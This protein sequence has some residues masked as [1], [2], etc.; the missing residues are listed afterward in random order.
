MPGARYFDPHA[1]RLFEQAQSN[2]RRI[3]SFRGQVTP[4]QA[5]SVAALALANPTWS[6]GVAYTLGMGGIAPDSAEARL[7]TQAQ[8]KIDSRKGLLGRLG[9]VV[10]AP[11]SAFRK[12]ADE[13]IYDPLKGFSRGMSAGPQVFK[14]LA[15]EGIRE[16]MNPA[17]DFS[18]AATSIGAGHRE[19]TANGGYLGLLTGSTDVDFGDG[20]FIGGRAKQRQVDGAREGITTRSGKAVTAGR[21]LAGMV[22]ESETSRG[23]N[24]LSGLVDAVLSLGL[25]PTTYVGGAVMQPVRRSRNLAGSSRTVDLNASGDIKE[26]MERSAAYAKAKAF[27]D[28]E[29][30]AAEYA[31]EV[32]EFG[33]VNPRVA[34]LKAAR[35]ARQLTRREFE[36]SLEAA[37]EQIK[38]G[39]GLLE[40]G[41]RNTYLPEK[42][43]DWLVKSDAGQ[44][45]RTYLRNET[46]FERMRQATKGKLPVA[47]VAK[48]TEAS[49]DDTVLRTLAD[50]I[51]LGGG[52]REKFKVGLLDQ[53]EATGP[54]SGLIDLG[55]RVR[56]RKRDARLWALLPG[57]EIDF[58]NMDDAVE[59]LNRFQQ[60][61]KLPLDE[62]SAN[63][64]ALVKADSPEARYKAVRSVLGQVASRVETEVFED[65]LKKLSRGKAAKQVLNTADEAAKADYLTDVQKRAAQRAK[66]AAAAVTKAFDDSLTASRYLADDVGTR[67]EL[68]QARPVRQ[69]ALNGEAVDVADA[70][71]PHL[72]LEG[73]GRNFPLPDA[74]AIRRVLTDPRMR[75]L[76]DPD[77]RVGSKT[78]AVEDAADFFRDK[79]WVPMKLLRGAYAVR[80]LIEAQLSSAAGGYAAGFYHPLHYL[81]YVLWNPQ[82]RSMLE[83]TT[84]GSGRL[85]K[86]AAR[87]EEALSKR[88]TVRGA[89]DAKGRGFQQVSADA[90]HKDHYGRSLDRI[91]LAS[92]RTD[93]GKRLLLSRDYIQHDK[94]NPNGFANAWAARMSMLAND[95]VGKRVVRGLFDDDPATEGLTG[96]DAV[97]DWF[98]HGGG[99]QFRKDMAHRDGSLLTREGAD[100]YVDWLDE[101]ANTLTGGN[102]ELLD[103]LRTGRLNGTSLWVGDSL[104]TKAVGE[105]KQYLDVAPKT[106]SGPTMFAA[107]DGAGARVLEGWDNA[108]RIMFQALA[109]V[110]ENK[111]SRSPIFRQAY[112]RRMSELSEFLTADA[113]AE[114][115]VN[116]RKAN[117]DKKLLGQIERA[118]ARRSGEMVLDGADE[119][120]KRFGLDEVQRWLYTSHNKTQFF[121]V[122]RQLFVF[123]DAWLDIAKRWTRIATERPQVPYRIGR[124]VQEGRDADWDGDDRGFFFRDPTT[125]EERFAW[126][127]SNMMLKELAGASAS[128]DSSL[129]SLNMVTQS[130]IP[131]IGP[132]TALPAQWLLPD[133]PAWDELR[134]VILPFGEQDGLGVLP[135]FIDKALTALSSNEGSQR[136]LAAYAATQMDVMTHLYS[137]GDYDL[138]DPAQVQ[139]L[140]QD[141]KSMTKRVFLLRSIAQFT[142]PASPTPTFKVQI[143]DQKTA[144]IA[145]LSSRLRQLQDEDFET[146]TGRFLQEFGDLAML[147]LSSKTENL[148]SAEPTKEADQFARRNSAAASRFKDVYGFFTGPGGE[149]DPD[150]YR[151]QKDR[152]ERVTRSP[153]EFL[154]LAE[155]RLASH[156]YRQVRDAVG[157][158]PGAAGRAI[159]RQAREVLKQDF[160]HYNPARYEPGKVEDTISRLR[161]AATDPDLGSTEAGQGLRKYLQLRDMVAR[162]ASTRSITDWG[163]AAATADLR[164][165]LRAGADA[166]SRDHPDFA[167]MFDRAL[168]REMTAAE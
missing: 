95:P 120:A 81:G 70:V 30:S 161:E 138:G 116:A 71:D 63:N 46:N 55:I 107:Q 119:V 57:H 93:D 3:E 50:E 54:T 103:M 112:W 123:G 43:Y 76:L 16:L 44:Q 167:D 2:R 78:R 164:D 12:V 117:L 165:V 24:I 5:A 35:D 106:I 60:N 68:P 28:G 53:A 145:L 115:L 118:A 27:G 152:G 45:L 65:S 100:A 25:D 90:A 98:F 14:E 111:L 32:M 136:R 127:G 83:E 104:N 97:K 77:T 31:D 82:G 37:R 163:R 7:V 87:G 69:L 6:P 9:D 18:L 41:T 129:K 49:D 130:V 155:Q 148:G 10:S 8:A 91:G 102:L 51:N 29:T 13:A 157:P 66:A 11:I 23:Y 96:I 108:V 101:S 139:D 151:A 122:T 156:Y 162:V 150:A 124:A 39:A 131:G 135:P 47:L 74:R 59:Q 73:L 15:D 132:A 125:G 166:I 142:L 89:T 84:A 110:P 153:E 137:S 19:V 105:L 22:F 144:D 1:D 99:Q 62:R 168:S 67:T 158:K 149:F 134:K 88:A 79:V 121:D 154:A 92:H 38:V 20:F 61:A 94:T 33:S 109:A 42:A 113:Q 21:G 86:A 141:S 64:L 160:T 34:A 128:F 36:Q 40:S 80:N 56:L 147:V 17:Q 126:P 159:L 133:D 85:R 26:P 48:L 114:M 140:L 4:E 75:A 58:E 143:K 146:A 52:I 72:W